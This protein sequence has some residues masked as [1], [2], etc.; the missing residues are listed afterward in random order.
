M[1]ITTTT[2]LVC[3]YPH[4]SE[5]RNWILKL[6]NGLKIIRRKLSLKQLLTIVTSQVFSILY[7]ASPVWLMPE[8]SKK[9]IIGGREITF[10]ITK[11]CDKR[12]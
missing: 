10:Q 3:W 1:A 8:V 11:N 6:L 7:Y 2:P 5:V 12:L 4:V 9:V